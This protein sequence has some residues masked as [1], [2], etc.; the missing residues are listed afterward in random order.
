MSES[1][2]RRQFLALAGAAAVAARTATGADLASEP[3]TRT[4][5]V[6]GATGRVGNL[7]VKQLLSAGFKVVAMSRSAAKLHNIALTYAATRR[8]AILQGDVGSDS[9]AEDL[10]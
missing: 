1:T 5:G 6:L 4:V 10:R 2:D 3:G 7:I 9:L 8:I